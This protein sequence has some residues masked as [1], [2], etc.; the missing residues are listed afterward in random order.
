MERGDRGI[1]VSDVPVYGTAVIDRDDE[2]AEV[3][4]IDGHD[5][6]VVPDPAG[7]ERDFFMALEFFDEQ[8]RL[9]LLREI[10]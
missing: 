10:V 8:P 1:T 2:D 3:T 9:G 7:I 5:D 4:V 6:P